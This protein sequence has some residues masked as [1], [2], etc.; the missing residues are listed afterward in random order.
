MKNKSQPLSAIGQVAR[1]SALCLMLPAFSTLSVNAEELVEP[2]V[3]LAQ[4]AKTVH[5]TVVD[6]SGIPF[7]GAIVLV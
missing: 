2:V 6:Q 1:L 5:G 3:A 4:Q 7:I